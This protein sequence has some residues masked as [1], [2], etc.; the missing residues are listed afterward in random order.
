MEWILV[1]II[2]GELIHLYYKLDAQEKRL[3]R[4]IN[5][6]NMAREALRKNDLPTDYLTD[7]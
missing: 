6:L 4:V 2:G 1:I 7:D 5:R 3:K